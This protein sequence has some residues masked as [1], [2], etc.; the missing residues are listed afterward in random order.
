MSQPRP[1]EFIDYQAIARE[2]N[3]LRIGGRLIRKSVYNI[4]LFKQILARRGLTSSDVRVFQAAGS[5]YMERVTSA[6][7][8]EG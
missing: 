5:C 4:T 6:V 8:S 2:Y 1:R 7:M 3:Q